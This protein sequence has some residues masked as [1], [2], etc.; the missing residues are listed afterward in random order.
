MRNQITFFIDF[1]NTLLNNDKVKENL[2]NLLK[3]NFGSKIS[4]EFTSSY[5]KIREQKGRVDFPATIEKAAKNKP[6]SEE[7][8]NLFHSFDFSSCLFDE[9]KE[10]ISYLKKF[11]T[12]VIVSEGEKHYQTLKIKKSGIWTTVNGKVEIPTDSKVK[13]LKY[14]MSKYKSNAFYLIEDKP[15][16]L[17]EVRN[18][19]GPKIKTIHIC[20]GHYS[21]ICKE[22]N[23]DLTVN[24]LKELK[25][26]QFPLK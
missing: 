24:S 26:L 5:E 21:P 3:E 16:I 22:E 4:Q 1:D 10:T 20:Q 14:L 8:H 15:E 13:N 7:I 9:A 2:K 23:F 12:V 19:Y 25:N 6:D 11:G 17:K 18:T